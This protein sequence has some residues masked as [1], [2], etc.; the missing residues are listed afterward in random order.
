VLTQMGFWIFLLLRVLEMTRKLHQV[1]FDQEFLYVT[2][3]SQ[4]LVIP[5]ENIKDVEIKTMGGVYQI[6]LYHPEQVGE[7]FF[8]KP[9]L[10]YPLNFKKKDA[11]V[12]LL[13]RNIA[14]AKQR[15]SNTPPNALGS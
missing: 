10:L 9:S 15:K 13:R 4:D 14:L 3:K 5:L 6:T 8:F 2:G 7:A 12:D 11:L 1:S